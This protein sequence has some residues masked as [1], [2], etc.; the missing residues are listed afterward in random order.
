VSATPSW[1][2]WFVKATSAGMRNPAGRR[3]SS[4]AP[5]ATATGEPLRSR[6]RHHPVSHHWCRLRRRTVSCPIT[7]GVHYGQSAIPRAEDSKRTKL[8]MNHW[9]SRSRLV[10]RVAAHH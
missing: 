6:L 2:G 1:G 4:H 8:L 5:R 9:P 3:G 7:E 10:T